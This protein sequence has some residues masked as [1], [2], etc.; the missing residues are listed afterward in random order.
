MLMSLNVIEGSH[1]SYESKLLCVVDTDTIDN[2]GKYFLNENGEELTGKSDLNRMEKQNSINLSRYSILSHVKMDPFGP[3]QVQNN[4]LMLIEKWGKV[5]PIPPD[6]F[7]LKLV[8]SRGFKNKY[9]DFSETSLKKRLK[10][11]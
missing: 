7:L 10:I 4:V 6:Q 8:H 2:S 9:L 5:F 3:Y 11:T 1:V